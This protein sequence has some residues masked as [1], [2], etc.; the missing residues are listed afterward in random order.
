MTGDTKL[1][2][3]VLDDGT[4]LTHSTA[5]LDWIERQ[6]ARQPNAGV[7]S[8]A[9]DW[10]WREAQMERA[11]RRAAGGSR[12]RRRRPAGA[13]RRRARRPAATAR[14]T[15]SAAA[16]QLWTA[17]CFVNFVGP[18]AYFKLGRRR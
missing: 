11:V 4:V 8:S 12:R 3:L 9:M 6:P 1:P 18:L 16:R 2:A 17:A 14:P 13:A 5:I 7:D 15:R 10:S